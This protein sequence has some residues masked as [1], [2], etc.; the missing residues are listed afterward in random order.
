MASSSLGGGPGAARDEL[1]EYDD[2]IELENLTDREL[3]LAGL[4]VSD[5][6]LNPERY[7]LAE[8]Q[9]LSI[10]P[11]SFL[12]L[13]ADG[14]T[15]QGPA[16][17]PFKLSSDGEDFLITTS[18]GATID[19]LSAPAMRAGQSYAR[20]GAEVVVCDTP[21]PGAANACTPRLPPPKKEYLPYEW[22]EVWPLPIE[23]DVVISEI[24]PTEDWIELENRTA[25]PIDLSTVQLA[26][27]ATAAP[28]LPPLRQRVPMSGMLAPGAPRAFHAAGLGASAHVAL[29]DPSGMVWDE[30][31]YDAVGPGTVL[32]LPPDG[33]GLRLACTNASKN[34]VNPACEPAVREGRPS[35][36]HA[37][38]SPS[39]FDAVAERGREATAGARSIKFVIDRQGGNRVYFFDSERWFLHFDWVWEEILHREP[40]DLCTQRQAHDQQW[41]IFSQQNYFAVEPRRFYL[42]TLMFY[43]E[44]NLYTVEFTAGD[45]ISSSMMREAFFLVAAELPNGADYALRPTTT[46]QETAVLEIEGTVPIVP[47]DAPFEGI[48]FQPLNPGVAFG[49]LERVKADEIDTAPLS[50]Q[51]IAILDEIPND[52][53]P[54][55]GTITEAFQTPLAHVNVLAQNR[56]TPNMALTNASSDPRIA[57]HLGE[58]VRFEVTLSGFEIRVATSSEAEEFWRMRREETGTFSPP[59][60]LSRRE[61]V[62]LSQAGFGD[63]AT[64][65]AKASQYAEL[66]NLD[67]PRAGGGLSGACTFTR[68]DPVLPMQRPAF[69]VPFSR[70]RDHLQAIGAEAE[71]DALLADPEALANPVL[72]RERL[73]QI[74]ELIENS[75]VDPQ[76]LAELDGLVRANFGRDRV[77][78]R[79]ST[80]VEDLA[81]F[82]G[83]GLYTSAS[84]QVD[85]E[86]RSIED[87]LRTVWA[88]AWSFRGFE[89]RTLFGVDQRAVNMGVLIHRGFPAEEANGVAI[90]RNVVD[91]GGFGYYIN[92][93]IGE[94]SVVNPE[95][96]DLPEQLVYKPYNPPEIVVLGRSTVT[97][98]SAVLAE[99]EVH[100]LGC[101][102][103]A[104]HNHFRDSA[105]CPNSEEEEASS[106]PEAVARQLGVVSANEPR[107]PQCF[108]LTWCRGAAWRP[109]PIER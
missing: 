104:A 71:I 57:P 87:A 9:E 15:H 107:E 98:G 45:R 4:F 38:R 17:L 26:L 25:S 34:A 106:P 43:P 20:V 18:T 91:P 92:A 68:L 63:V 84:A 6:A 49:V 37:L 81:G 65:G 58:L 13:F 23:G 85:S 7:T 72:R 1:G 83:A 19:A 95:S 108:V 21:T 41:I 102:L 47:I 30:E 89:E 24:H 101:M 96:G 78:F 88:S 16:H 56:R 103:Q 11:R 79:S 42:G 14:E 74:R 99:T 8:D 73:H 29:F 3:D 82:N 2:W 51:T 5:F 22:P 69:A 53:P 12:L 55:G 50:F 97:G 35:V 59:Q 105:G 39:D 75:P 31:V 54:L 67:W 62:D 93:Q 46:R 48:T 52:V 32:A 27:G 94:I 10:A 36:L 90:T 66:I 100:R 44:T 109:N 33:R 60:D 86:V 77:R 76:L 61:L 28:G 40:F 64:I 80:N 70:Y